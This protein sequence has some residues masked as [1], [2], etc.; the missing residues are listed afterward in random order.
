MTAATERQKIQMREYY[1]RNKE[2][3][4]ARSAHHRSRRP[5]Y[6]RAYINQRIAADPQYR[7]FSAI[8]S[9]YGLTREAYEAILAFQKNQCAVCLKTLGEKPSVD[10]N[11]LTGKVR[12]LVHARCNNAIGWAETDVMPAAIEYLKRN[13]GE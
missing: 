9:A 3:L 11:H 12:G 10:H 2:T 13:S 8:K 7:R 4:K 6:Q 5:G 1:Q